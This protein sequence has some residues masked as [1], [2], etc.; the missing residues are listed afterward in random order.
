MIN[1]TIEKLNGMKLFGMAAELKR[2]LAAPSSS[3]LPFEHRV[4][5]MV[6]HETTMRENKR[7]QVLLKKA[8]LPDNACIEDIDYRA[9]RSLDK[10]VMLSLTTLD[11]IRSAH[12]LVLT[13]PTGTGKTWL[14]CAL[15]NQA[16]RMGL[17]SFF[18]RVPALME[19][20]LA[21]RASGAFSQRIEQLKKFD[22]LILDDWGIDTFSK[23]AQN[24]LLELI[25]S[26]LGKKSLIITSQIPMNLWH[27]ELDNKTIADAVMDRI[28]HSSYHIQLVGETMR[29]MKSPGT[30][31][32]P[33]AAKK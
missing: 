17:P 9:A 18:I 2:Q 6:D 29:K 3:D 22:L 25:D 16:C 14:S 23:R 19:S 28:V 8:R 21:A 10:S 4:R 5:S 30:K 13:G 12:N 32:V 33:K 20:L 26:R 1:D 7:L 24:D 11:W 15:A 27:D 31:R